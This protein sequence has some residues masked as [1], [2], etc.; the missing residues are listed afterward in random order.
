MLAHTLVYYVI[1]SAQESA[2][3]KSNLS[4]LQWSC[5]LHLVLSV[6][7]VI[8]SGGHVHKNQHSYKEISSVSNEAIVEVYITP[9]I[10]C[11]CCICYF[12]CLHAEY[13]VYTSSQ[14]CTLNLC[15]LYFLP[16][17]FFSLSFYLGCDCL[18][19]WIKH[20]QTTSP[21]RT[22]TIV[23]FRLITNHYWSKAK[24]STKTINESALQY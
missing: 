1:F 14:L 4:R 20:L 13:R 23:N 6:Y 11:I 12:V 10:I 2:F 8:V 15:G 17:A 9:C 22:N 16:S 19:S 7:Y 18:C 21:V 3:I 24:W 5:I